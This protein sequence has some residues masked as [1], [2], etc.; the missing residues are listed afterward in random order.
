MKTM[1][2]KQFFYKV[3]QMREAQAKY[4]RVRTSA[5]LMEAKK[6]E[7]EIDDEIARAESV[8]EKPKQANL[9][10]K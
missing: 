10:E 6:I 8:V 4:F 2:A 7:T 3:K 9:F 5:A 1:N